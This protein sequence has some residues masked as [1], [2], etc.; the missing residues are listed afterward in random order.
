MD[1]MDLSFEAGDFEK[2]VG[3]LQAFGS[4]DLDIAFSGCDA[5]WELATDA[6]S[7]I[8]LG[9]A[10]A[11]EV[12]VEVLRTWGLADFGMAWN[13][14][15]SISNLAD[16]SEA[17]RARLGAAGACVVVVDMLRAWG[18]TNHDVVFY[19]RR[20]ISCLSKLKVNKLKLKNLGVT[21]ILEASMKIEFSEESEEEL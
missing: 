9:N 17:N 10:G 5:I 21:S 4:T 7:A 19:G 6:K 18:A 15:S 12:V 13:G 1:E 14:C 20:A 16:K 8:K 3:L 11:C 2:G